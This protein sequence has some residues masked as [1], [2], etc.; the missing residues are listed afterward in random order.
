[1]HQDETVKEAATIINRSEEHV[2]RL[3]RRGQL[4]GVKRGRRWHV[5]GWSIDRFLSRGNRTQHLLAVK[6]LKE[7][8]KDPTRADVVADLLTRTFA[9]TDDE[10]GY[11]IAVHFKKKNGR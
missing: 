10:G 5:E 4:T 7:V 11:L 1:M 3:L 2:R 8:P 6:W 9:L